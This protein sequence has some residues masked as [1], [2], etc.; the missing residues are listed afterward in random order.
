MLRSIYIYFNSTC[1]LN[2]GLVSEIL[3]ELDKCLLRVKLVG[4]PHLVLMSQKK[5]KISVA[6]VGFTY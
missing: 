5:E 6:W 4:R 2:A 1:S 3:N